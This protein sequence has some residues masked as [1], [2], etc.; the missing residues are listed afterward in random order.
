MAHGSRALRDLRPQRVPLVPS[1]LGQ[2]G[3][4]ARRQDSRVRSG[5]PPPARTHRRGRRSQHRS[6]VERPAVVSAGGRRRPACRGVGRFGTVGL[7]GLL[8]GAAAVDGVAGRRGL[9]SSRLARCDRVLEPRAAPSL[10]GRVR[11]AGDGPGEVRQLRRGASPGED[12]PSGQSHRPPRTREGLEV[13]DASDAGLLLRPCGP[14]AGHGVSAGRPLGATVPVGTRRRNGR[15]GLKRAAVGP[16]RH[17]GPVRAPAG[18]V[19]GRRRVLP[20]CGLQA[21]ERPCRPRRI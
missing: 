10:S 13:V 2:D 17:R 5:K 4:L 8:A 9:R 20:S 7:V 6:G 11:P 18:Q 12:A 19:V 3:R 21:G 16:G 15:H 1:P 14:V